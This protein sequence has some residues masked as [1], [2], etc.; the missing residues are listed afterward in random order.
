MVKRTGRRGVV[1]MNRCQRSG[2]MDAHTLKPAAMLAKHAKSPFSGESAE[3]GFSNAGK[4][5]SGHKWGVRS[6]YFC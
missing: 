5:G 2:I 1:R 4:A 6:E 3:F